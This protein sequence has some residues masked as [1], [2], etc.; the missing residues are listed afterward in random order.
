MKA[1]Y[2]TII[3]S[4]KRTFNFSLL[5]ALL[6]LLMCYFADNLRYSFFSGPSIGQR[7]EQI[8]E[9]LGMVSKKNPDEYVFINIAYDKQLV[10]LFDEYGLPVGNIDIT[11]RYKLSQFIS[12]LGNKHKFVLFDVLLSEQYKSEHDSLLVASLLKTDRIS[13]SRSSTTNLIDPR[14]NRMA[15]YTDYATDLLETSFVKYEFTRNNE[16]SMPLMAYQSICKQNIFH[17]FAPLYWSNLHLCRNA[18]TLHFPIKPWNSHDYV[19]EATLDGL[20]EKKI[21]NLG[22][23]ILEMG[24]NIPSLVEDKIVVIGDFIENDI[25]DTYLGKIA[26]PIIN[27]NAFEALRNNRLQIPWSLIIVLLFFYTLVTYVMLK[28]YISMDKFLCI[29]HL[30]N[31]Y[32]KY[33]LSFIGYSFLLTIVGGAIYLTYDL[34]INIII[35]TIWFTFLRG[36][37]N[38]IVAL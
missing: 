29:L 34:D 12:E 1:K 35:P 30:D 17:S 21:L 7:I 28:K 2:K 31:V 13:I 8:R 24:A 32:V 33:L 38:K 5:N 25:H 11:D 23:D 10:P 20:Q 19:Q 15:G 27:V 14:L 4:K 3:A 26:G 6:I 16:P 9:L 36:L 18:L 37:T 22:T